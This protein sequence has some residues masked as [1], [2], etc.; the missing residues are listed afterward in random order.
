MVP[1]AA[2]VDELQ[3]SQPAAEQLTASHSAMQDE[4]GQDGSS[5][6]PT[7]LA[8]QASPERI[9]QTTQQQAMEHLGD[10][11]AHISLWT[12]GPK[13]ADVK[14]QETHDPPQLHSDTGSA[15]SSRQSSDVDHQHQQPP[16]VNR[17]EANV[18]SVAV[19]LVAFTGFASAAGR[20]LAVDPEA[21]RK[22]RQLFEGDMSQDDRSQRIHTA[23]QGLQA[24]VSV[25]HRIDLAY[26]PKPA[27]CVLAEL[28]QLMHV[29][30]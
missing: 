2:A 1:P 3:A 10:A 27:A 28:W 7:Q 25:E 8:P 18:P 23:G 24:Q 19:P 20:V 26:S 13:E 5:I 11:A 21:M 16:G 9:W 6:A 30:S 22:A 15:S 12:G 17:A 14:M 4:D 29:V